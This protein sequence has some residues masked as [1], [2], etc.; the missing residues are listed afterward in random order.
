LAISSNETRSEL[1][2]KAL[3]ATAIRFWRFRRASATR[4]RGG[5]ESVGDIVAGPTFYHE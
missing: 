4:A 2:L 1:K 5:S 3:V